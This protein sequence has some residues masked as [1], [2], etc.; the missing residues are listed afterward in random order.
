MTDPLA[1]AADVHDVPWDTLEDLDGPATG[2]PGLLVQ[3]FDPSPQE[4]VDAVEEIADR[5]DTTVRL[6][7]PVPEPDVLTS[8]VPALLPFLVR[9]AADRDRPDEARVAA[10][11]LVA[12]LADLAHRVR[13]EHLDAAWPGAWADQGPRVE[14]LLGDPHPS[15][16]LLAVDALAREPGTAPRLLGVLHERWEAVGDGGK[17]GHDADGAQAA[18][19]GA[20]APPRRD[21]AGTGAGEAG[22]RRTRLRLLTR[23]VRL[24]GSA[25]GPTPPEV[26]SWLL[27]RGKRGDLDE[28]MVVAFASP[29]LVPEDP[30]PL[31]LEGIAGEGTDPAAVRP[32]WLEVAALAPASDALRV[33]HGLRLVARALAGDRR[34]RERIADA[35]I[36]HPR[37][38]VRLGAVRLARDLVAEYRSAGERWAGPA[39]ALLDDP[40]PGVRTWS[41][42]LLAVA[43][44]AAGPCA[45]RLA[46]LV[47]ADGEGSDTALLTLALV[48]DARAATL[49]LARADRPRFGFGRSGPRH[50]S[51]PGPEDVLGRLPA[52]ADVLLPH[53]RERL[54]GGDADTEV[55]L[56]SLAGWGPVAAPLADDVA[57]LL[58][59]R[60]LTG[61]A[62]R[63]LAGIGPAA[64]A[65]AD[66]VRAS[67]GVEAAH[68]HHRITGDAGTALDLLGPPSRQLVRDERV[69]VLL[70]GIG[71]PAD[72]F[73]PHLR[74]HLEDHLA[75]GHL[76]E[77]RALS[78]LWS[79]TG[80]TPLVLR[81][82]LS[83]RN[84]VLT[85][86]AA[87]RVGPP[88]VRLLGRIGPE[89]AEAL[90]PLRA[91][92]DSGRRA[93]PNWTEAGWRDALR[94]RRL[95]DDVREAIG[96]IG[97]G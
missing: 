1:W 11:N 16:L 62:L 45:D 69:Q 34:G 39:G 3:A 74:D 21:G 78:A 85:T 64:A 89:A 55:L 27:D 67:G 38:P 96:R 76:R 43:G 72:R 63:V 86:W 7:V 32:L 30:L 13:P 71:P 41:L 47:E 61:A 54:R 84:R 53:L 35:L 31:V 28:R 9:I 75:S 57:A 46:A 19:E 79:T 37:A 49:L 40:D 56:R 29:A 51:G 50:T 52:H 70:D 82:L 42:Q 23:A 4:A 59:D 2:I 44:G 20:G 5:V 90:P 97:A 6:W 92:R 22:D 68:A 81:C 73:A 58:D 24:L 88:A 33:R 94:D 26:R 10:L 65:H 93:L 87:T 83:P 15:V 12:D 95:V 17:D 18:S 91:L 77:T 25:P 8:S 80:D 66:R 36:D 14:A 60:A 48:G